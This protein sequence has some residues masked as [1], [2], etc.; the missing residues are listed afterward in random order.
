MVLGFA[1]GV[2][3]RAEGIH[4]ESTGVR[5]GLSGV[6]DTA[7][8]FYQIESFLNWNLP[9]RWEWESGWQL[10][11]RLD[12]TGGWINGRGEDAVIATVG[13]TFS[14]SWRGLPLV[15]DAGSSPTVLGREQFGKTDFGTVFQFT[16]HG[17]LTWKIGSRLGLGY[18]FQH[19]SN[20]NIGPSN[21]GLNMHMLAVGWRF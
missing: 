9:W 5:G 21:P 18:R 17:D 2:E 1:A 20:A 12:L 10:Q 19:M 3:G 4:L 15:L 14:L 6:G 13:P 11:S 16:T 8:R 7:P